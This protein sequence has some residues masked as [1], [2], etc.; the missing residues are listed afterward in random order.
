MFTLAALVLAALVLATF[1]IL[2]VVLAVP[3]E[4]DPLANQC[5]DLIRTHV[6]A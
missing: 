2:V 5:L 4:I 3:D 6:P 1:T